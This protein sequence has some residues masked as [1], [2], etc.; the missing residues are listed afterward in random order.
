MV[1]KLLKLNRKSKV[2]HRQPARVKQPLA[3]QNLINQ[4][5]S[6]DFMSD[7]KVGN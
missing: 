3:Q 6:M 4:N 7:S 5:W 1:Y 2:K